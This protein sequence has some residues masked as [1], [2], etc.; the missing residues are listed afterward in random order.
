MKCVRVQNLS[1]SRIK[2]RMWNYAQNRLTPVVKW[3]EKGRRRV[4]Q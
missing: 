4:S 3:T 2:S 1:E